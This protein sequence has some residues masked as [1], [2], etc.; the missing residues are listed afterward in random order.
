[1]AV[2]DAEAFAI[3]ARCFGSVPDEEWAAVAFGARWQEFIGAARRL[4]AD[5]GSLGRTVAPIWRHRGVPLQETLTE[6]E[7]HA[8]YSPPSPSDKRAFA[9]RHFVGGLDSSAVPVE[10]LYVEWAAGPGEHVI[11]RQKGLYH[12]GPALYMAHLLES[13]G[14]GQ[15]VEGA[16]HADHLSVE[17]DLLSFLLEEGRM[18]EATRFLVERFGWLAD[19]RRRLWDVAGDDGG[20]FYLAIIDVILGARARQIARETGRP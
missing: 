19:Y 5:E 15:E 16:L 1:M 14:L 4:L 20:A 2:D 8:L 3:M 11:A 13:L 7:T 17:L 10:S 18:D 9:A 6:S 12:A